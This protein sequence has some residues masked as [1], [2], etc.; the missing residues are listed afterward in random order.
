MD[1]GRATDALPLSTSPLYRGLCAAEIG[2][3]GSFLVAMVLLLFVGALARAFHHPLVWTTDAATALF[4]WA[5]FLCADVAWR[6]DQL[7]SIVWL[8]NRLPPWLQDAVRWTNYALIATFLV[9]AV[10][11]GC[12]LAWVSRARSFQGIPEISYSWVTMSMPVGA[13]LLL[14]TTALKF[15][16][17][18]RTRRQRPLPPM[19]TPPDGG[20]D[21]PIPRR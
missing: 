21:A 1:N 7:M 19:P 12:W 8:T 10:V 5:C 15:R 17:E 16:A 9:F 4:A 14:L 20:A 6:R 2:I 11:M 3:A 13:A 18:W